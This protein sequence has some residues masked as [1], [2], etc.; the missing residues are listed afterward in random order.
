MTAQT[1][2]AEGQPHAADRIAAL[3]VDRIE[4]ALP[5]FIDGHAVWKRPLAEQIVANYARIASAEP[6]EEAQP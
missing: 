2:P 5:D 4:A 1:A 3:D 6:D